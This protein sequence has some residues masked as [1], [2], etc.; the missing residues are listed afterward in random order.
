ML[1]CT[2]F[3]RR[4]KGNSGLE[5]YLGDALITLLGPGGQLFHQ[6]VSAVSSRVQPAKKPLPYGLGSA[7][8]SCSLERLEISSR[9]SVRPQYGRG[10]RHFRSVFR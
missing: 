8:S 1:Q 3:G 5:S 2:G 9:P 4:M 6:L 7:L 10:D